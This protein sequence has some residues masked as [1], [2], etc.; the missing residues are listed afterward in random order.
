MG[1][2]D[3]AVEPVE[4]QGEIRQLAAGLDTGIAV[5]P[6]DVVDAQ[7]IYSES[8]VMLVKELRALGAEAA[9]AHPSEQRVFEVKKGVEGLVVAFVIG[10]A[11]TASWD[12]MKLLLRRCKDGHL[13][14]TF[15]ELEEGHGRRG[16]AWR[17]E[18]D[19][20]GVIRAVDALRA[21][22]SSSEQIEDGSGER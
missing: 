1:H 8:S 14:L 3:A 4:L 10:I 12:L 6:V 22:R 18:G 15:L 7:G 13:S 17:I 20:D 11:S 16:S 2:S 5:L 19:A 21:E 9:F